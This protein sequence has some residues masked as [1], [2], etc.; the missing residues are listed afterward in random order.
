MSARLFSLH[1]ARRIVRQI[2]TGLFPVLR[3]PPIEPRALIGA[4]ALFA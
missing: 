2:A 1:P 4:A 3:Q